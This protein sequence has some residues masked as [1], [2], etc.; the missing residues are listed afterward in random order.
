MGTATMNTG[1]EE[2]EGTVSAEGCP[3]DGWETITE[4]GSIM[5]QGMDQG[6]G[7]DMVVDM[8]TTATADGE[9]ATTSTEA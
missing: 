5:E 1:W 3:E 6:M 9:M 2:E 7:V 8:T 4:E